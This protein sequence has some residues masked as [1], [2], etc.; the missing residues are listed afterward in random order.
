MANTAWNKL[1]LSFKV[2]FTFMQKDLVQCAFF[3]RFAFIH[4][5]T[6]NVVHVILVVIERNTEEENTGY[7][8]FQ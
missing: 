8:V 5:R 2:L 4:V 6:N 7:V 3:C 1:L